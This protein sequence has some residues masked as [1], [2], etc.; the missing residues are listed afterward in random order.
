ML[1]VSRDIISPLKTI[2]GDE[3]VN[4]PDGI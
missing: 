3:Q 1:P 4:P 2:R